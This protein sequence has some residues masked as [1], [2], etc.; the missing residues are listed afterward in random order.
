[1][2]AAVIRERVLPAAF[3]IWLGVVALLYRTGAGLR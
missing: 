2:E 1:M 3:A